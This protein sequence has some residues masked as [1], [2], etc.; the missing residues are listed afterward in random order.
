[1]P[2][3]IPG[4]QAPFWWSAPFCLRDHSSPLWLLFHYCTSLET[5]AAGSRYSRTQYINQYPKGVGFLT[6]SLG[7]PRALFAKRF[8]ISLS[9]FLSLPL[10]LFLPFFLCLTFVFFRTCRPRQILFSAIA[11]RFAR[12]PAEW[13]ILTAG[14]TVACKFL[15]AVSHLATRTHFFSSFLSHILHFDA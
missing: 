6:Q 5:I 9:L 4:L 13:R 14:D 7:G 10:F 15:P 1:M 8:F 2:F 11:C 12:Q 3:G